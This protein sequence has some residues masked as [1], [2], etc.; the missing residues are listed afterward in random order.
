MEKYVIVE[1]NSWSISSLF[2]ILFL[3]SKLCERILWLYFVPD[4][5]LW[6]WARIQNN[7]KQKKCSH[8]ASKLYNLDSASLCMHSS[9]IEMPGN[10]RIF[11]DVLFLWITGEILKTFVFSSKTLAVRSQG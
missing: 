11:L 10:L 6:L 7:F 3:G 4:Y 5:E 8:N 9:F 2:S 1:R